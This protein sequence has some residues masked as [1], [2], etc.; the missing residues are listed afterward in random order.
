MFGISD[1]F[2]S[3]LLSA[4]TEVGASVG[5]GLIICFA[6]VGDNL[7]GSLRL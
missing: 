4:F 1:Y 5:D 2:I 7:G 6:F 3:A